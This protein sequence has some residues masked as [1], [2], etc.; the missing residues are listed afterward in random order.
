MFRTSFNFN[1]YKLVFAFSVVLCLSKS[2]YAQDPHFSQYYAS[3]LN[4]N[5]ALVGSYSGTFRIS[6]IYR[7]QWRFAVD[8][9]LKT[10]SASGDVK[11]AMNFGTKKKE[12]D[13]VGLG[14]SFFGDRVTHFDFN[15]NQI[16]LSLGYH[17]VLDE[18]TK[19]YLGI[20]FQGGVSQKSVNYEDLEFGDQFNAINGYTLPTDEALPPNNKAYADFGIGLYYSQSPS[21]KFGYHL[22]VGYFHLNKPNISYYNLN[23]II[24]PN[25]VKVST[26][27]PKLSFHAGARIET[28]DRFSV[29]PRTIILKQDKD[30]EVNLGSNFRYKFSKT[31]NQYGLL[32]IY[33]RGVDNI[34][35]FAPESIT[36]MA[37][38]ERNNF[39]LG[40]SYDQS[41]RNFI[42][43]PKSLSSLEVSLIYIG[44]H[45]NDNQFCPQF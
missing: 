20:A 5:P 16:S 8:N 38:Y 18:K 35:G 45:S 37:G 29:E 32:G 34:S 7:D 27:Q 11:I 1:L 9:P 17:K 22:G 30:L 4:L 31:S 19:Q 24:D 25:V 10:F 43:A 36:I 40:F 15:T 21:K 26:I 39:I 3:P 6:T 42:D 14:I 33:G 41:L 44:E 28:S 2:M 12:K 23:E 13:F